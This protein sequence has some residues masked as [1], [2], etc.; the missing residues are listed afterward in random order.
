MKLAAPWADRN[1]EPV[2]RALRQLLPP[3]GLVL[4]LA[5]GSGQHAAYIA[6][7]LPG[8]VWQPTDIDPAALASIAAWVDE[9]RLP[10][11]RAPLALDVLADDW[12]VPRADAV[13]NMNM[14]HIAPWATCPALFRGAARVLPP[15]GL[16]YLYGPFFLADRPAARGN[17]EFDRQLRS[18]DPAWGVR[19]LADVDVAAQEA[20]FRR[21]ALLDMPANNF[22]VLFARD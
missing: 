18:Q 14:L 2:C 20:G 11:L 16:V 6:R 9:V 8:L 19:R 7:R 15:G 1:Q 4:E 3:T 17:L 5:G 22:S 21:T 13:V 12:P 10:N